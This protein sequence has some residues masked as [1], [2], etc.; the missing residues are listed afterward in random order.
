MVDVTQAGSIALATGLEGREAERVWEAGRDPVWPQL[1][2][3]SIE[4]QERQASRVVDVLAAWFWERNLPTCALDVA[5]QDGLTL[6]EIGGYLG[7]TRERVRQ[8]E[9]SALRKLKAAGFDLE[10]YWGP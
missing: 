8:I 5:E 1:Y 4:R 10:E 7:L 3:Y 9:A 6:E 2:G